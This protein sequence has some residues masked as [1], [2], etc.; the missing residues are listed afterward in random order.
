MN[1]IRT[2]NSFLSKLYTL[3]T[4][5]D[6][7]TGT[8]SLN[9]NAFLSFVTPG[10]PLPMAAV[11]F[12]NFKTL[13]DFACAARFSRFVNNIPKPTGFWVSSAV[14]TW[15][16]YKDAINSAI[17][18]P[19]QLTAQQTVQLKDAQDKLYSYKSVIDKQTGTITYVTQPSQLQKD[20]DGCRKIYE[21]TLIK[22]NNVIITAN[23]DPTSSAAE[24]LALNG[25]IYR[26]DVQDALQQWNT[27]R[28]TVETAQ[29]LIA[30]L[31]SDG[32]LLLFQ[33]M[34]NDLQIMQML[35]T[36]KAIYYPTTY[37]PEQFWNS[38]GWSSFSMAE[39]EEHSYWNDS[40]TNW[41]GGASGGW[42]LW[43]SSVGVSHTDTRHYDSC[44]TSGY[45]ISFD[46]IQIPLQRSW[47]NSMLFLSRAWRLQNGVAP[48]SDGNPPPGTTGSLSLMPTSMLVARN[49]NVTINM[50]DTVNTSY[51]SET[52]ASGSVGWGPFSVRGGY[53]NVS[54][55]GTHDYTSND[56]GIICPGMQVIGFVCDLVP[57]SPNPD[58][59]QLSQHLSTFGSF[60]REALT[61]FHRRVPF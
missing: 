25:P 36:K 41:G 11:D 5:P 46:L 15:Q 55:G 14:E 17:V 37:F 56:G 13:N 4:A 61:A 44:N 32:P 23:N 1:D 49:L 60:E 29:E 54:S 8:N 12:L 57:K 9:E 30:E 6:S 34:R 28:N 3:I 22:L 58:N 18:E 47:M 2:M 45:K 10:I 31:S 33:E 26:Q 7:E 50:T 21:S 52:R 38:N 39:S 16:A 42:G 40:T 43:S 19:R 35:D 27:I 53:D 24:D 59:A 51:R 20:Y 48:L